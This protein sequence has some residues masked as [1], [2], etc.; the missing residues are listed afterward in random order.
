MIFLHKRIAG[1]DTE[2][3]DNSPDPILIIARLRPEQTIALRHLL[4]IYTL[5][6]LKI[7]PSH[8]DIQIIIPWNKALVPGGTDHTSVCQTPF[9]IMLHT[10]TVYIA[11]NL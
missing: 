1:T 3:V 10:H 5:E 11:E 2:S 9:Q 7:I 4:S 6:Y 8:I